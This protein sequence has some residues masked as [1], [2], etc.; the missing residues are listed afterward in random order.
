MP[1]KFGAI[2]YFGKY[3]RIYKVVINNHTVYNGAQVNL[4]RE[5]GLGGG[6]GMGEEEGGKKG[7]KRIY[8]QRSYMYWSTGTTGG[9]GGGKKGRRGEEEGG[10]EGGS[11]YHQESY[12]YWSTGPPG[13]VGGGEEGGEEGSIGRT[14]IT[15]NHTCTGAQVIWKGWGRR[16]GEVEG[17]GGRWIACTL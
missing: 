14:F 5:G 15:S 2:R 9:V 10:E 13:G 4:G 12:T 6:G 7:G 16:G 17:K 11:I 8:N 3:G 1:R